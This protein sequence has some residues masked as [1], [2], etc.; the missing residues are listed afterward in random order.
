M[1][2]GVSLTIRGTQVGSLFEVSEVEFEE[3]TQPRQVKL[4]GVAY[5]VDL[6]ARTLKLN[7]TAVQWN[8]STQIEGSVS[9]LNQGYQVEIEGLLNGSLVTAQ[10][11]KIS[12]P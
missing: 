4:K 11:M 8:G 9:N 3:A 12:K 7:A 5:E 2:N 10:K 6:V 1:A